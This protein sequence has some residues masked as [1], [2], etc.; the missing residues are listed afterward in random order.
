M[1]TTHHRRQIAKEALVL[2]LKLGLDTVRDFILSPVS[3][4]LAI[5]DVV[6]GTAPEDSLFRKLMQLGAYSDHWIDVFG[7]HRAKEQGHAYSVDY[8]VDEL[9]KKWGKRE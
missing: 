5:I 3:I 2:Q 9:D 4:A 1:K 8:L 6:R 7:E